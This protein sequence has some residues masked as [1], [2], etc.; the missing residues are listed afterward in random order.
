MLPTP[1]TVVIEEIS[2]SASE[3]PAP[4]P[5]SS[6]NW[7]EEI[8]LA[9]KR[10]ENWRSQGRKV[11]D[12]YRDD[13]PAD[14]TTSGQSKDYRCNI[15]W[16][17]TEVLKSHLCNDLGNPDVRRMFPTRT[18]KG[19]IAR[20]S[21]ELL[22]RALTADGNG[23]DD[24][25]E[26]EAGVEDML[27]PGRGQIWA[28]LEVDSDDACGC[29]GGEESGE[30]EELEETP[31]RVAPVIRSVRANLVHVPWDSFLFGSCRRW[32]ETPW[33]ARMQLFSRADLRREF[34]EHGG[35]IK[36]DYVVEGAD[37]KD[38]K[39]SKS[40]MFRRAG[41]WEIWCKETRERIYVAEGYNYILRR[42][43]DPYNLQG[44][45]P[46]PRP[47]LAVSTTN[48]TTPKAEYL[49]YQDQALELDRLTYRCNRLTE[50]LKYG[51]FYGGAA[52]DSI[53]DLEDLEDGEFTFI[54]NFA[55]LAQ[56]GGL[57]QAFMIRDLTP[58][59]AA[60]ERLDA[61]RQQKIQEIYELTG[62][63]D[64]IRG[65]SDPNE[66]LGAQKLKAQ[67]GSSRSSRRQKLVQRWIRDAYRIKAELIAEHYP[68]EQLAEMTSIPLP[69]REEQ[70]KAKALAA[71]IQQ[72]MQQQ[73]MMAQQQAQQPQNG[74]PAPNG[75]QQPM[76]PP[77]PPMPPVDPD[78]MAELQEVIDAIAWEDIAEVIRTDA[79]RSFSVDVETDDTV[80]E[81]ETEAKQAATEFMTAI[82]GVL[83]ETLPS[84]QQ[85]PALMPVVKE[86]ILFTARAFKPGIGFEDIL[87]ETLDNLASQPPAPP[88][89][90]PAKEAQAQLLQ[91]KAEEAQVGLETKKQLGA[92]EI[93][94]K[95][96]MLQLQGLELQ[97]KQQ[98]LQTDVAAKQQKSQIDIADKA[99]KA[100]IT[101]S[102]REQSARIA[103]IE[104]AVEHNAKLHAHEVDAA[105]RE[106]EHN[107]KAAKAAHDHQLA[108]Q[109]AEFQGQSQRIQAQHE[110]E[111]R[112]RD[113]EHKEAQRQK[114][115]TQQ[116]QEGYA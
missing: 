68:R 21:A 55:A 95:Q 39:D 108:L 32:G 2:V 64:I 60:L 11:V 107:A 84:V 97:I 12:R 111:Q 72:G 5:E 65:A 67:F 41:V 7:L 35:K 15:L 62:I 73:A 74:A 82:L 48:T 77:A 104:A 38:E 78:M 40:E 1:Q 76:Q 92:L 109:D 115:Q 24:V 105:G 18:R 94:L 8:R 25:A 85:T 29:E 47:L 27:L 16:S 66:T 4:E 54:E 6:A 88:P 106:L 42:D 43:Q 30:A 80:F 69:T 3:T 96:A 113:A 51:G 89:V 99:Q 23:V 91:M 33:V 14:A 10:E 36:M 102:E 61:R 79:R 98:S 114:Q 50:A 71:Q 34:P 17:N 100:Q 28:E 63:S 87:S 19:K 49:L 103:E 9:K 83:T 31:E 22:E 45:F 81:D 44:F 37:S 26:F 56:N 93:Q 46:C 101:M 59:A 112:V 75:P 58:I 52:K 86:L 116:Q 110:H 53:P 13:R 70:A 20:A 57:A 90:D